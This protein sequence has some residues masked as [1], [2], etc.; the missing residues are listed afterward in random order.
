MIA[1]NGQIINVDTQCKQAL[2]N[3]AYSFLLSLWAQYVYQNQT[4]L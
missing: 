1:S 2:R 4:L 3:R